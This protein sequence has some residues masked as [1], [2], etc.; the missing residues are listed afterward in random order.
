MSKT[1][2]PS[3]R[4]GLPTAELR[5]LLDSLEHPGPAFA[6]LLAFARSAEGLATIAAEPRSTG[7]TTAAPR[8]QRRASP[9]ASAA[10]S[11]KSAHDAQTLLPLVVDYANGLTQ[12]E[13]AKKRGIHVQTLR[14]RLRKAGVNTR[15]RVRLLS[16]AQLEAARSAITDGASLRVTARRLDVSHTTLLRNLKQGQS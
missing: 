2:T 5:S 6:R 7:S 14:K 16:P 15:A 12:M 8:N 11:A 4:S 1:R 9:R 3:G 10:S 13:I